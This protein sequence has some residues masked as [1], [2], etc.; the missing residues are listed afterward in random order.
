V[1]E[2][3][4][5]G[6]LAVRCDGRTV[7]IAGGK[8]RGLLVL[9]ALD[10]G[11]VVSTDRLLDDLWEGTTPR[12]GATA[13]R[14]VV[15]RLRKAMGDCGTAIATCSKGYSLD[16][17]D[18]DAATFE[19]LFTRGRRL[20]EEGLPD[21]AASVLRRA[22]A[23]WRADHAADAPGAT[24]RA[25]IARLE[26]SR[27]AAIECRVD[28]DLSRG[29][30]C[31][32]IA[33]L[34]ELTA[35]HPLREQLW[36]ARIIA[37]YRAR[38]QAE[39]L[40]AYQQLRTTLAEEL[41]I[42]PSPELRDLEAAVLA[43]A[44]SLD[45]EPAHARADE[46]LPSGV[47]TFLL[48]DI[49]D[50][51]ALWDD[52]P[53]AMERA[54]EQHDE[55]I[56]GAVVA[57][58]GTLIKA[59]G[60]GDSSL[61]VFRRASDAVAAGVELQRRMGDAAWPAGATLQVR[62]AI[63]TGEAHE[64]DGDY[65]G[66]TVNRAARLRSLACGGEVLVS[67][68]TRELVHE[69]LPEGA[70]LRSIGRRTLRGMRRDEHVFELV[71]PWRVQAVWS[72]AGTGEPAV[73]SALSSRLGPFFVGRD[74]PLGRLVG[75]W[76]AA[77]GGERRAV[78][79]GGEPGIGKTRL[80]AELARHV[81][82]QGGR[83]AF[84][85]SDEGLDAPYQPFIEALRALLVSG[86]QLAPH[87]ATELSRL[88]P[89]LAPRVVGAPRV[90]HP[91]AEVG[92]Y[93]LFDAVTE[94]LNRAAEEHPLLFVVDDLQWAN[95]A[96][97]LMLRHILAPGRTG[98][99]LVVGTYRDTDTARVPALSSLLAD[100]SRLP[101]TDRITLTGLDRAGVRAYLAASQHDMASAAALHERTG[102]NPFF[103]E[104]TLTDSTP[105]DQAPA[106]VQDVVARRLGEL[107]DATRTVL[108]AAAV[109]GE[110]VE[111][112]VLERVAELGEAEHL[113]EALDEAASA[114]LVRD[115][116]GTFAFSHAIVRD[117]ILDGTSATRRVRLHRRIGEAIES[118][119]DAARRHD[120]LA[121]HFVAAAADGDAAKA[122]EYCLE[123]SR[124][125][126]DQ[127]AP[128]VAIAHAERGIALLDAHGDDRQ[129]R[130]DLLLAIANADNPMLFGTRAARSRHLERPREL[131]DLA[132]Q[133]DDASRFAAAVL[134]LGDVSFASRSATPV[135]D[136]IDALYREALDRL[137]GD[138]DA[139]RASLL[140]RRAQ[141]RSE[142]DRTE[143]SRIDDA[144]RAL[145][146]ARSSGDAVA[147][148][149]GLKAL[150]RVL[151]GSPALDRRLELCNES[152]R[153]AE[154]S[155]Q[156]T[157]LLVALY[158]R[159]VAHLERGARDD[160]ETDA[161]RLRASHASRVLMLVDVKLATIDGRFD[162]AARSV[163]EFVDRGLMPA[164]DPG[165]MMVPVA[166]RLVLARETGRLG[167]AAERLVRAATQPH[168]APFE[169]VV[170]ALARA[171]AHDHS[172]AIAD[173]ADLTRNAF[174]VLP[175]DGMYAAALCFLAE[176]C[177]ATAAV[178]LAPP[179][180]AE[181]EPYVGTLPSL[182][183]T[184]TVVGAVDRYL[185]MLA[186]IMGDHDEASAHFDA[187]LALE[188]TLRAPPL[189]ARTQHWYGRS[190]AGRSAARATELLAASFTGA[191]KLGMVKLAADSRA[192]L[193]DLSTRSP[194]RRR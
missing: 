21:Q 1:I 184:T 158:D 99:V 152:V 101:G 174:A 78:F 128:D 119:P 97:M 186:D 63:H 161:E 87:V 69:A 20:L 83:V 164:D 130:F 86:P 82:D 19:A 193:D 27:L 64:R 114:R 116:G 104:A 110:R 139:L 40:R 45:L 55:I 108:R 30:H 179:L 183:F 50:S 54:L 26:Q 16:A 71:L 146:L 60:E 188:E 33:E 192:L 177:A 70:Q 185:G 67:S 76:A 106:G 157:K 81:A 155:G 169:R 7:S 91:T 194:G 65:Y 160:A 136:D 58:G 133:L 22:T 121:H 141:Q 72:A 147:L 142:L 42:D 168:A 84:G 122:V 28:A 37:L 90:A 53:T 3:Q 48:T 9:L 68:A 165:A 191:E 144:E 187:A 159:F 18:V 47:I 100:L 166:V 123:A 109:A 12:S 79:I 89:E 181:L 126:L 143:A 150:R 95:E 31:E 124:T 148:A 125:A 153:Q 140:A 137:P 36:R 167:R 73:P 135:S 49:V 190:L 29:S 102:G 66:P 105:A 44:R 59:Q 129:R 85:R 11:R 25:A 56:R 80:A 127:L 178:D 171:E 57:H 92:R 2:V 88:L 15:S 103:L 4:I 35:A 46:R 117:A 61:S 107:S 38:R 173:V 175:R 134:R 34:E 94:T 62:A 120:Q 41:G 17:A 39:A 24:G 74:E 138:S 32:L 132:R 98:N 10:V 96:T 145:A 23:L 149:E 118:L 5:L 52:A 112:A 189:I 43:Q 180:R 51:T 13:L 111:L 162:D 77:A 115:E 113:L 176:T 154:L 182:N 163:Q 14:V 131:V 6:P 75:H 170:A 8:E 151:G 156:S 172:G 93:A